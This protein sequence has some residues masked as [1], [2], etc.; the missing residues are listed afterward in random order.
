VSSLKEKIN[1]SKPTF[2][3]LIGA[4]IGLIS[5][6]GGEDNRFVDGFFG[7]SIQ[8]L[9]W[10]GV[11]WVVLKYRKKSKDKHTPSDKPS[12]SNQPLVAKSTTRKIPLIVWFLIAYSAPVVG[13]IW[14]RFKT[15]KSWSQISGESQISIVFNEVMSP[16]GVI[17]TFIFPS[18]A[19]A[20]T[21]TSSIYFYRKTAGKLKLNSRKP[22]LVGTYVLATA[23]VWVLLSFALAYVVAA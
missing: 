12:P 20:I 4:F 16:A 21:I 14:G 3:G 9:L 19:S 18:L 5:A 8:F 10:C 2:W 6:L 13:G 17:D 15:A 7:A 22:F 23:L 11:A 1:P